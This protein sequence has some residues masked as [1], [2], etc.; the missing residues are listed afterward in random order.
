MALTDLQPVGTGDSP[1]AGGSTPQT[2]PTQQPSAPSAPLPSAP[3]NPYIA[4]QQAAA[5]DMNAAQAQLAAQQA[6]TYTPPT[7][8]GQPSFFGRLLQG[9]LNGLAGGLAQGQTNVAGAG[10]PGFTPVGGG[11][12]YAEKLQQQQDQKRAEED[13]SKQDTAQQQFEND[14]ATYQTKQLQLLQQ[15]QSAKNKMAVLDHLQSLDH[16]DQDARDAQQKSMDAQLKEAQDAGAKVTDIKVQPGQN[17]KDVFASF[18][19]SNPGWMAD[20]N[21]NATVTYD[22]DGNITAIHAFVDDSKRR[23]PV[24]EVNKRLAAIPGSTLQYDEGDNPDQ[25]H[26]MTVHDMNSVMAQEH[27]TS[28]QRL[29]DAKKEKD[30]ADAASALEAQKEAA[31][32]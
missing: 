29:Y 10:T 11:L 28:A 23:V 26:T 14:R 6:P 17:P 30:K 9:A 15:V 4:Q 1:L 7:L 25:P 16:A 18:L 3:V 27:T 32:R 8:S 5:N 2:T 12:S 20:P 22:G 31:A 13:K 19:Q 21:H 24:S